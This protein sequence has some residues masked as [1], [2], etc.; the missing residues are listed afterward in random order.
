VLDEVAADSLDLV[1]CMSVNPGWSAQKFIPGSLGKLKRLRQSLP[2]DVALEVD[3]GIH[4]QTAPPAAQAGANLLVAASAI[5]DAP[6]PADAYRELAAA[7]W[8]S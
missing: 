1:L 7:A 2:G 6:S 5:F 4:L 3:G 8:R